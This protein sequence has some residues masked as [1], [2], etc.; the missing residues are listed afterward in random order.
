MTPPSTAPWGLAARPLACSEPPAGR[1]DRRDP[2]PPLRPTW[3]ETLPFAVACAAT[4][5]EVFASPPITGDFAIREINVTVDGVTGDFVSVAFFF[6]DNDTPVVPTIDLADNLMAQ[7]AGDQNKIPPALYA[8][9]QRGVQAFNTIK[10]GG[11]HRLLVAVRNNTA[12]TKNVSGAVS[13]Q[14]LVPRADAD[15][16]PPYA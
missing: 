5:S 16:H 8:S 12:A 1:D 2:L 10:R 14:H 7:A 6:A 13:I 11:T 15:A 3:T 9:G 4:S